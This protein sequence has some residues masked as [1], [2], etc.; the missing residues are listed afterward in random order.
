MDDGIN[1]VDLKSTQN[2]SIADENGREI[3]SK[4]TVWSGGSWQ[5]LTRTLYTYDVTGQLKTTEKDG[6]TVYDATFNDG[7]KQ[8]EIDADGVTTQFQS[9]DDLNRVGQTVRNGVTTAYT[10]DAIVASGVKQIIARKA[11]TFT[12]L[13]SHTIRDLAGRVVERSDERGLVTGIAYTPQAG[14]LG[15]I[16]T[17]MRPDTGTEVRTNYP[18]GQLKSITGTGVVNKAFV[19]TPAT[20]QISERVD[21]GTTAGDLYT[22]TTVRDQAK[23]TKKISVPG[24]T[25]SVVDTLFTY[26]AVGQLQKQERKVGTGAVEFPVLREYDALGDQ[27]RM[28]IDVNSSGDLDVDQDDVITEYESEFELIPGATVWYR[29][30]TVSRYLNET[31]QATPVSEVFVRM[32]FDD[33]DYEHGLLVSETITADGTGSSTINSVYVDLSTRTR[34]EITDQSGSNIQGKAVYIDG[35]LDRVSSTESTASISYDYDDFERVETITDPRTG[36]KSTI[37]YNTVGQISQ[38]KIVSA[39]NATTILLRDYAYIA[40]GNEGAGQLQWEKDLVLTL[41]KFSYFKYDILGNLTHRWGD[42]D[43]PVR[44]DYDHRSRLAALHTFRD[45]ANWAS[46]TFPGADFGNATLAATSQWVYKLGTDLLHKKIDESSEFT[47]YFYTTAGLLPDC[48]RAASCARNA[49]AQC[50][51]LSLGLE[52]TQHDQSLSRGRQHC[53]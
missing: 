27:T 32:N 34:T 51:C 1:L 13:E 20:G 36:S 46:A 2:I 52:P 50:L 30:E 38:S 53:S 15:V 43:Y 9:Y 10:R 33:T 31:T 40:D 6:R 26:N 19:Y 18:D 21:E 49:R 37:S 8:T 24:N 41:F 23:R 39:D 45:G 29:R 28:G 14:S 16:T 5:P 12:D 4:T 7:I 42:R 25:G 17:T 48:L 47:E 22:T 11:G 3:A 44:Y 35:L